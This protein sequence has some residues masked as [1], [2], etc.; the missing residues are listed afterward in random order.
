MLAHVLDFVE[1]YVFPFALL[2]GFWIWFV[3]PLRGACWPMGIVKFMFFP[4]GA[5]ADPGSREVSYVAQG[6]Y[7]ARCQDRSAMWH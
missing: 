2:H 1:L 3:Y 4:F 7:V 5:H 6:S